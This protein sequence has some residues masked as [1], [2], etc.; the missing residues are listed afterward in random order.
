M[1]IVGKNFKISYLE[2][3]ELCGEGS[4]KVIVNIIVEV[5]VRFG[6]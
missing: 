1:I 4:V 2:C 6:V 3:L 5:I